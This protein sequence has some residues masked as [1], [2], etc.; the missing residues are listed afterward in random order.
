MRLK[1]SF[2]RDVLLLSGFG[3]VAGA[4][5]LVALP[6]GLLT[7]GAPMMALALWL[8]HKEAKDG[9]HAG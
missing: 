1:L 6:L 7:L 9:K 2:F 3:C 4:A 5:F 8:V